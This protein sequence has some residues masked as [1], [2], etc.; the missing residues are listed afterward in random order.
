MLGRDRDHLTRNDAL[1]IDKAGMVGK[2]QPMKAG[3]TT[4]AHQS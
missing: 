1:V 4:G 2:R 3:D